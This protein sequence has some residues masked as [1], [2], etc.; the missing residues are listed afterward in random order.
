[1]LAIKLAFFLFMLLKLPPDPSLKDL[2]LVFEGRYW[3]KASWRANSYRYDEL[4]RYFGEDR[5]PRDIFRADVAAYREWSKKKGR[6]NTTINATMQTFSSFYNYLNELE[7]VEKD[8]NPWKGML[9]KRIRI[10]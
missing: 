3:G 1:M 4:M 5:R 8:Y 9:P 10:R 7:L 6:S 2:Q